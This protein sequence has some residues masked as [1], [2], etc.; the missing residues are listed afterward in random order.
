MATFTDLTLDRADDDYTLELTCPDLPT[1]TTSAFEVTPA[2]ATQLVVATPPP[3]SGVTAGQA[4]GLAVTVEDSFGNVETGYSG[5]VTLAPASNPGG[6]T[7]GGTLTETATEGVATFSN[8]TLN[9]GANGLSLPPGL[10]RKPARPSRPPRSTSA[11]P[12]ARTR[13]PRAVTA[14]PDR[15][16]AAAR[17]KGTQT[18]NPSSDNRTQNDRQ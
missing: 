13:R 8:L 2:P 4:F 6:A 15:P 9:Q 7:V 1:V 17:D 18:N 3:P 5:P 11:P 14:A 16:Q 12:H 10:L